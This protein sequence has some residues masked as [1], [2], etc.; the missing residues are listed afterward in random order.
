MD[1]L[2]SLLEFFHMFKFLRKFPYE[3]VPNSDRNSSRPHFGFIHYGILD[4]NIPE[5]LLQPW[6]YT[7]QKV[8]VVDPM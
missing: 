2:S 8:T 6:L 1:S 7:S 3:L 4:V 5:H